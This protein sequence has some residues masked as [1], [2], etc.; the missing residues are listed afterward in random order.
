MFIQGAFQLHYHCWQV[1][2][3]VEKAD[4][5]E[6]IKEHV[7]EEESSTNE[8]PPVSRGDEANKAKDYNSVST[9][10][11]KEAES[12]EHIEAEQTEVER[13]STHD[14]EGSH[15]IE[16]L[17]ERRQGEE[18]TDPAK[19][20]SED[21]EAE[22]KAD[23][24]DDLKLCHEESHIEVVT[25]LRA[26]TSLNDAVKEELINTLNISSVKMGLETI[27]GDANQETKEVE[28]GQLEDISSDL[29]LEVPLNDNNEA[30]VIKRDADALYMQKD[31][32]AEPEKGPTAELEANK[33]E[34]TEEKLDE[35]LQS[36]ACTLLS[37]GENI[38]IAN[39]IE[40]IEEEI[41]K[42]AEV[43][44]ES[45]EDSSDT[46]RIEEVRL[47]KE[48]QGE[49]KVV[50]TIADEGLPNE[51]PE[52]KIQTIFS[53]LASKESEHGTGAINE[54]IEYGKTKEEIPTK[55]DAVAGDEIT[56]IRETGMGLQVM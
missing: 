27:K 45:R 55:L 32:V 18:S 26:Q 15:I 3:E 41:H 30:E 17:E 24:I 37:E 36:S 48:E 13:K 9:E 25:D 1:D 49:L 38:R 16:E 56:G 2:K 12:R 53:T 21:R 10:C 35:Q 22:E 6:A 43:K 29:A 46:K 31:Q 42:D 14:K 23:I 39:L 47:P 54:E 8:L 40:N 34:D 28:M 50:D 20:S 5:S 7:M 11:I 44:H 33:T 19:V 4:G 51:E 52:E